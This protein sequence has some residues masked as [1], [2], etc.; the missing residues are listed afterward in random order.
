MSNKFNIET[1]QT[2]PSLPYFVLD[3]NKR[4]MTVQLN[5]CNL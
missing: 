1:R 5:L 2:M 3:I 4:G